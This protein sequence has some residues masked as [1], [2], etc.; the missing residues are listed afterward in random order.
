MAHAWRVTVGSLV[1][2]VS[3]NA[4]AQ[5]GCSNACAQVA[6]DEL[7]AFQRWV[8]GPVKYL[9]SDK[10]R[11]IAEALISASDSATSEQ[12]AAFRH[13]F[14]ERRDPS[15]GTPR[16]EFRDQFLDRIAYVNKE[17]GD[18]HTTL[19]GYETPQGIFYLLL[20]PPHR[21]E[22]RTGKVYAEFDETEIEMWIYE[23]DNGPLLEL[24]FV[25][26]DAGTTLLTTPE[27]LGL[28][29][30]IDAAL[31]RAATICIHN[32]DLP[33][34]GASPLTTTQVSPDWPVT[35][36]LARSPDGIEGQLTVPL[37]DLYGRPFGDDLRI[38]LRF[39]VEDPANA[40]L[41]V[42]G[43]VTVVIRAQDFQRWLDR[44]LSIALWLPDP[45]D[46]SS[47]A[48]LL[49]TE[50]ASGRA[51][52]LPMP[53]QADVARAY[54]V[55]HLLGRA[56]LAEGEGAAFAFIGRQATD[57]KTASSVWILRPPQE[58]DGVVIEELVGELVMVRSGR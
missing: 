32:R 49:I 11:K 19:P 6:I 15:P 31:A 58:I 51:V 18:A 5:P 43:D 57:V 33:F 36:L 24:P 41:A 55:E 3:L 26:T 30:R 2:L 20:G 44:D 27:N 13:W 23:L 16:N 12:L 37:A 45:M 50:V 52:R 54:E 40:T 28:H 10:E 42:L 25:G 9:L 39:T 4:M 1:L 38:D 48:S 21:I 17:F 35:G 34:T 7:V 46:A 29:G 8:A 47:A 22:H 14:W 53:A 56:P